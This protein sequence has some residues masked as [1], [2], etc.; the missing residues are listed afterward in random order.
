VHTWGSAASAASA[1]SAG[2]AGSGLAF[3]GFTPLPPV[4]GGLAVLTVGAGLLVATRRRS[5]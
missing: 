1:A 2:N 4:V 3:T 5:N